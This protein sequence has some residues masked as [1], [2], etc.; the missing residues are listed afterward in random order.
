MLDPRLSTA[1]HFLIEHLHWFMRYCY[2]L[3]I[4]EKSRS[5]EN[6]RNTLVTP[7]KVEAD[8]VISN[9]TLSSKILN[10]QKRFWKLA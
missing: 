10:V 5:S 4:T 6:T 1:V 7:E 8:Y 9:V 3:S 2:Y